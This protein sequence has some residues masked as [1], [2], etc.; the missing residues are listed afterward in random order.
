MQ[1]LDRNG[2]RE[3]GIKFTKQHIDRLI[4]Q[5]KFPRP[6]KVGLNTNAWLEPEI[7]RYIADRI[8]QR[9]AVAA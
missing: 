2:L 6:I 9:D 4:R 5:G 1:L 3:K 7:D 8:A